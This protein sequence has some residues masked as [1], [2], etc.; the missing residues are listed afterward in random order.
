M[1]KVIDVYI[2]YHDPTVDS[3]RHSGVPA[4][5]RLVIL[6]PDS[7]VNVARRLNLP[8]IHILGRR[9]K[10]TGAYGQ[11]SMDVVGHSIENGQV[12]PFGS[13]EP[14]RRVVLRIINAK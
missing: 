10:D 3:G 2:A 4:S 1:A 7:E 14:A 5:G 8:V 9:V 12:I 6:N 13:L 11:E